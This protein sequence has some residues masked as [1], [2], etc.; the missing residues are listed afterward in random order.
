MGASAVELELS[1]RVAE[2]R[3]VAEI[4]ALNAF[5]VSAGNSAH[6]SGGYLSYPFERHV[7]AAIVAAEHCV[8][9]EHEGRVVGYYL[10]NAVARTP[11]I[12]KREQI[13]KELVAAGGIPPARYAFQT[14]AAVHPGMRGRRIGRRLL[15]ELKVLVAHRYDCLLGEVWRDN[16]NARVAHERVGWICV[17]E[18]PEGW[19]AAN[20]IA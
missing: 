15:R 14:Q 17:A 7:V 13:V 1:C 10:I 11:T 5:W 3:D 18:I 4:A 19:L 12:E 20:W 9:A 16:L 6:R 2:A 8:V